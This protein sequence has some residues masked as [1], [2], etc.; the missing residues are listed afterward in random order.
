MATDEELFEL[1]EQLDIPSHLRWHNR[2]KRT[3]KSKAE[4]EEQLQKEKDEASRLLRQHSNQKPNDG[5]YIR[6]YNKVQERIMS[7]EWVLGYHD[8]E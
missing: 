1:E 8:E 7:L 5:L 3:M 6:L 4:I 2:N